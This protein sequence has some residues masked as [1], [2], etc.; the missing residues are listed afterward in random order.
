MGDYLSPLERD[1]WKKYTTKDIIVYNE[2]E[3]KPWEH[4][5]PPAVNLRNILTESL[6]KFKPRI[7]FEAANNN[8][9]PGN[10]KK[11]IEEARKIYNDKSNNDRHLQSLRLTY[12]ALYSILSEEPLVKSEHLKDKETQEKLELLANALVLWDKNSAWLGVSDKEPLSTLAITA[13]R[14]WIYR[15]GIAI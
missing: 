7:K 8:Y 6:D 1:F 11:L 9:K 13:Y 3:L 15:H 4:S 10:A 2:L 12:E 5:C 14:M